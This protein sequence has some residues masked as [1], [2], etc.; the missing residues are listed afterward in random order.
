MYYCLGSLPAIFIIE[1]IME[2][3]GETLG[4]PAETVK[5]KN[6]YEKGQVSYV[7]TS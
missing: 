6:L 5:Q 1:S 4:I 2:H 7:D 3:V